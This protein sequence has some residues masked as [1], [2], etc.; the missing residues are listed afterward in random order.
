LKIVD[1]F[2]SYQSPYCY[3][4]LDRILQL[5][6]LKNVQVE[7]K[8]VLPG[9]LRNPEVFYD[10]PLVEQG[11]FNLD[12]HRTAEFLGL[13][14]GEAR[15]YPIE[16]QPGTL[17]RATENQ[18]RIFK[19]YYLSAAANEMG[20]GWAFL[21]QVTRLIWDGNRK[22]W[23]EANALQEAIKKAGINYAELIKLSTENR[24]KYK[25]EFGRNHDQLLETG[26]NGVPT[27]AFNNEPFFG[28]DRFDQ[29]LWRMNVTLS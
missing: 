14:Y 2:W 21:N 20:R 3:F 5:G 26:H 18:P 13:P 17:F 24:E 10:T 12:T 11:Y 1:V 22:D 7:L 25:I 4:A 19:L 6:K 9:V 23:H 16:F 15:P 8:L 27:F 28:H 29:L